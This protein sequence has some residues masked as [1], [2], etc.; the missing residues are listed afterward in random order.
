MKRKIIGIILLGFMLVSPFQVF[1]QTPDATPEAVSEIDENQATVNFKA[2]G[3][4]DDELISPYDSTR[5][6]FGI[7][8]HWNLTP[9]AEVTLKYDVFISGAD[10]EAISDHLS[11]FTGTLTVIFN[12]YIIKNIYLDEIGSHSETIQIPAE[13][14]ISKRQDGRHELNIFLDAGLSCLYDIRTNVVIK[15]DSTFF[16]PYEVSTPELDLSQLPYPFYARDSLAPNTTYLVVPNE[17]EAGELQAAINV[18]TGFGSMTGSD[19]DLELV[20]TGQLTEEMLR[21]GNLIFVGQPNQFEFLADVQFPLSV[22]NGSFTDLPESAN[23]DGIVQLATSPWDQ[24][25]AVLLVSGNSLAAIDKAAKAVSTGQIFT[26]P[27]PQLVFVASINP[28][29]DSLPIVEDFTL[30]DLGYATETISDIGANSVEYSFYIAKEQVTS[31]SAYFELIFTHSGLL[32]YN[33]SSLAVEL[34]GDTIASSGLSEESANLSTL[35]VDF[36]TGLLR[37]G[38]NRLVVSVNLIPYT[39][40]DTSGFSEYWITILENSAFHIPVGPTLTDLSAGKFD[41]GMY[42]DL[43]LGY[44]N[45]GNVAYVLPKSNPLTWQIAAEIAFNFGD[46]ANPII[47]E[48]T[49]IFDDEAAPEILATKSLVIIGVPNEL[50][51]LQEINDA[52]PAPFDFTNNTASEQLL[53]VSYRIPNNVDIGYL[54]LIPSPYNEQDALMVVAGNNDSGVKLAGNVLNDAT[55]RRQLAGIFSM[56]NGTQVASNV[57]I[58]LN[59]NNT[60]Q[61]SIIQTVV[62]DAEEIFTTPLPPALPVQSITYENP[63]WLL[64][65]LLV[66]TSLLIVIVGFILVRALMR[67]KPPD[68]NL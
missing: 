43:F 58:S 39:S 59:G 51:L 63:V 48:S 1:A 34:N 36:P 41:F 11:G 37:F 65:V 55:L 21:T 27:D 38:E 23:E 46:L 18:A 17:P 3:Y 54:E 22:L 9:G 61:I 64:P 44:S 60:E 5:V 35:H 7:P 50:S 66:S 67:R 57:Q 62:P 33:V 6:R 10:V 47:S 49:V 20:S 68:T 19:F 12:D 28:F 24:T 14:L 53:Q 45:L 16:L 26:N 30:K 2:L 40:C 52:L 31:E 25:K 4:D 13:A 56:T 32:D 29:A 42:P 8:P 15:S